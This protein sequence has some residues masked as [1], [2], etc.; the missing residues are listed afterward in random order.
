MKRVAALFITG[1]LVSCGGGGSSSG[2]SSSSSTA[3]GGGDNTPPPAATRYEESN[4]AVSLSGVWTAVAATGF[5]WSGDAAK[6]STVPGAKAVFTFTGTSVTWIGNRNVRSG[7]ALVK[8]DGGPNSEV[9]LFARSEEIHT[10]VITVNGLSA[11][12]HTLTIEVTGRQ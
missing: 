2:G 8:V 6:Q 11:A 9:D 5:G 7:I 3:S 12:R 10:P 1:L 4:A